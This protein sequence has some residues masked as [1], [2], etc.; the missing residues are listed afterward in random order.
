MHVTRLRLEDQ[1]CF[2]LYAA[3]AA[4]TR[5]YRPML[6]RI[7]LTYP[8]YL[9]MMV[10]WEQDGLTVH[11]VADRLNLPAHA[12]SPMLDRLSARGLLTRARDDRDGRVVRVRLTAEGTALEAMAAEVQCAVVDHTHLDAAE[13]ARL[14]GDLHSLIE[15]MRPTATTTPTI[16]T[17]GALP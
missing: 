11:E 17:E 5:S 4:V 6:A 13:L 10:L 12:M 7:G 1:L 9:L 15:R 16:T 14:R 3:T 8:Q 2:A